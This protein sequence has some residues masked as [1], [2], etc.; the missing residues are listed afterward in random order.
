MIESF[1]VPQSDIGKWAGLAAAVFS[2]SQA[3]LGIPWGRFSDIYGRKPAILLGLTSTMITSLM[4]GFSKSLP[5]AIVARA[6][7]GAGNG[8]VGIIRTTVAEMVPFKEL[9]PRAFSI[10]PLVWNVGSIF[11]PTIGG[12]LANPLNVEPGERIQNPSLFERFPY[13]LPNIV[14]A[15]FFA[16]GITVGILY[17]EETLE[18]LQGHRDYGR[19]LGNKLTGVFRSHILKVEE[20]LRLRKSSPTEAEEEPLLKANADEEN[21]LPT[22][23]TEPSPPPP[24]FREVMTKQ[25][26]MNLV[27]VRRPPFQSCHSSTSKVSCSGPVL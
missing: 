1:G 3:C 15:C 9:Q 24:S 21:G 7:A 18:T 2:L 22:E 11:G 25:S 13:A 14:S 10:M 6:L 27:V 23:A 17:L 16:V 12:A 19:E 8:N 26:I 20:I 4:W 5:M